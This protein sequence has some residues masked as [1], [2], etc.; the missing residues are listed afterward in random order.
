MSYDG[1]NFEQGNVNQY[2]S[3]QGNRQGGWKNPYNG[4]G[5]GYN[6]NRGGYGGGGNRGGYGGGNRFG[7]RRNDGPPRDFNL[8]PPTL[9][10]PFIVAG[11]KNPPDDVLKVMSE[12]GQTL[13]QKGY[14]ARTSGFDDRPDKVFNSTKDVE[15]I[16]PWRNFAKHES[17]LTFSSEEAK[18]FAKKYEPNYDGLKET[19]QLFLAVNVR[20]ACGQNLKSPAQFAIIWTED[21]AEKSS[22]IT[23]RTGFTAHLIKICTDMRIPVFNFGKP[24]A[25]ERLSRFLEL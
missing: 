15:L 21:G 18:F 10:R 12:V 11:N 9:Y 6:N 23:P 7:G 14:T 5:G 17:K 25:K 4:N 2:G 20:L 8:N 16:L 24:D 22:E 1:G 19:V 13:A 3:E